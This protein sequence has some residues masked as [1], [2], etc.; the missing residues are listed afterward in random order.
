MIVPEFIAWNYNEDLHGKGATGGG[1]NEQGVG[2][3]G[4]GGKSL[5]KV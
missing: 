5:N 2:I 3:G 4:E 1:G